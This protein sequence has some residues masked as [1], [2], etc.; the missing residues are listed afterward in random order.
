MVGLHTSSAQV[1]SME[2]TC[3]YFAVCRPTAKLLTANRVKKLLVATAI[4]TAILLGIQ[5]LVAEFYGRGISDIMGM[6]QWVSMTLIMLAIYLKIGVELLKRGQMR[7]KIGVGTHATWSTSA[8]GRAGSSN[9]PSQ[10]AHA[11]TTRKQS[12][13][14]PEVDE[15]S[16]VTGRRVPIMTA[17]NVGGHMTK[18]GL[19]LMLVTVVFF[20]CWA[21]YWLFV[22][23]VKVPPLLVDVFILTSVIN[24]AIYC[25]L[26]KSFRKAALDVLLCGRLN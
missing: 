21:P 13:A 22:L 6:T 5:F 15:S 1:F 14:N 25:F 3:R 8:P 19:M 23:N 20:A 7:K 11:S 4:L 24:P 2:S 10:L 17:K 26:S 12:M 16:V 9:Q 18:T